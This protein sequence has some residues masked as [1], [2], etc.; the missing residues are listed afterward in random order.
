MAFQSYD[1]NSLV[2]NNINKLFFIIKK[3]YF[4]IAI[5]IYLDY[6]RNILIVII[7]F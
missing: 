1:K 7:F 2:I 3:I 6:I 5:S 4:F